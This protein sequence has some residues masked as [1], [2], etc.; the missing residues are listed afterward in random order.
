MQN[1]KPTDKHTENALKSSHQ[2]SSLEVVTSYGHLA[3]NW[4][5][6]NWS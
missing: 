2:A 1:V 6:L 3:T 5:M 4:S